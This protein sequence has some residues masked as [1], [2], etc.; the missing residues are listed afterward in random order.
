MSYESP[1][2]HAPSMYVCLISNIHVEL[3]REVL[4]D[5]I[6]VIL[7]WSPAQRQEALDH[8]R[9]HPHTKLFVAPKDL[10]ETRATILAHRLQNWLASVPAAPSPHA[11]RIGV[12][13]ND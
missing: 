3:N 2:A 7:R 10:A 11:F 8:A 13:K 4:F 5:K 12:H 1:I 9:W 6:A